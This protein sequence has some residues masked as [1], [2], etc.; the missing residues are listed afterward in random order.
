MYTDGSSLGNPGPGGCAVV[1]LHANKRKTIAEGYRFTTNNRMELM[2]VVIG[3]MA[4][5]KDGQYIEVRSDSKYVV[6]A[7]QKGWLKTWLRNN[8][9]Q[10]KNE[11][12]WRKYWHIAQKHRLHFCW[13]KGHA[14]IK[15]NEV[16]DML[17]KQAAQAPSKID[18]G[19]E[20][21]F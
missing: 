11:D 18:E 6:D 21:Y 12:L 10:K 8:F 20:A 9:K 4:F 15:E 17:A 3:L 7:I 14:S 2:A 19:Y 5:K 16:C 1:L 13:I